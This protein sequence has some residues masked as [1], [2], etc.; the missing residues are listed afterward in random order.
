MP[1]TANSTCPGDSG[2]PLVEDGYLIGIVSAG[3]KT[4]DGTQ[5]D[6]VFTKAGAIA[7]ELGLKGWPG[8]AGRARPV[9]PGRDCCLPGYGPSAG[10]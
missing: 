9:G 10:F 7:P 6:S 1:G 8:P 5:P 2:G 3:N 4:C